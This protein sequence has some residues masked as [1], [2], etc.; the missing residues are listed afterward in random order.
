[1]PGI[2]Y[3]GTDGG[4]VFDMQQQLNYRTYLPLILRGW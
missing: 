4:G 2:L 3:A 1:M